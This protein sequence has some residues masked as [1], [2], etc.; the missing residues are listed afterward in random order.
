[1]YLLWHRGII[2]EALAKKRLMN[3]CVCEVIYGYGAD[4]YNEIVTDV[5]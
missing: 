4:K 3:E 5:L 1:V 2:P